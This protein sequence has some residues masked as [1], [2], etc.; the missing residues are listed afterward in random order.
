MELDGKV[1]VVYGAG[2]SMGGAIA[3]AFGTAGATVMLAGRTLETLETVAE[4]IG[5]AGGRAESGVVDVDDADAVRRYV[6]ELVG[7][8]GRLDVSCNAVGMDDVQNVPLVDLALDDFMLSVDQ[9]M[10]RHFVTCTA[11]ARQM[12]EQ[13]SGAIVMLT[14]SA[15][16]EWR[17]LMGGFSIAC[18]AIETFTRTLAAE[19]GKDGVRVVCIRA[20]FT[21]ETYPGVT[22]DDVRPLVDD[23]MI[24]RLPRLAEVGA[25]AVYAASDAAGATT[26]VVIDLTCGAIVD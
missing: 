24:G 3:R 14:A 16:R 17:H 9:A 20:N 7:R 18:G 15:A 2:G 4:E 23:T 6:D 11:A 21:P 12:S 22:E 5:S 25:A 19:V 1:A 10:R 26:G 8:K 13:G